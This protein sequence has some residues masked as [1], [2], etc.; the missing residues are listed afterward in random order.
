MVKDEISDE[1]YAQAKQINF[2]A[3]Y[4]KIPEE[5]KNLEIFILIQNYIDNLWSSFNINSK[6][7]NPI[8]N[9][10]FTKNLRDM[11]PSKLMNYMMQS[12]ET[13]RNIEIMKDL[14]RFLRDKESKLVL[15]I[16][17]ALIIDYS[18]KDGPGVF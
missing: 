11:H 18:E 6:I 16:Y 12:L 17:D 5:H 4:G 9:K 7:I 8:S 2:Q 15:Y 10:A 13:A 1:E 14:F 3:I